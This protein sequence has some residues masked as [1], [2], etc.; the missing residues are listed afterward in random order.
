M[1]HMYLQLKQAIQKFSKE[2]DGVTAIEYGLIAAATVVI[3]IASLNT[4][5]T[6]LSTIFQSIATNI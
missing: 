5:K 2:E 3:I 4:I 1:K 6:G